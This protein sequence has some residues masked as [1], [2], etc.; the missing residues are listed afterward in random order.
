MNSAL[1]MRIHAVKSHA[2]KT[3]T[4][5]SADY[6]RDAVLC[7]LRRV[8]GVNLPSLSTYLESH[9]MAIP[10]T[11]RMPIIIAAFTAVQKAA[12]THED[13]L[14]NADEERVVWAR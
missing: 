10:E 9:V 3:P 6:V 12:D 7:M 14:L 13:V 11:W 4:S 5:P 1:P 2:Q 8:D